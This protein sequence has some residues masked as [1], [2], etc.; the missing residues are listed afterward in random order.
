MNCARCLKNRQEVY[1]CDRCRRGFCEK[2]CGEVISPTE[3]RVMQLKK[4]RKLMY[5]CGDCRSKYCQ[6]RDYKEVVKEAFREEMNLMRGIY[7]EELRKWQEQ[8]MKMVE[9]KM[10]SLSNTAMKASPQSY[11]MVAKK[12]MMEPALVV[13]PILEQNSKDTK[14]DIREKINP[15]ELGVGVS[16]FRE[17]AKGQ[18]IIKTDANGRA[19]LEEAIKTK[20]ADKYEVKLAKMRTP[21]VRLFGINK[22][23]DA[24]DDLMENNIIEQNNLDKTKQDFKLKISK[25]IYSKKYPKKMSLVLDVDPATYQ[26]LREKQKI[27][28]GWSMVRVEDYVS[29]VRCYKCLGYGHYAKECKNKQACFKCGS[30]HKGENCNVSEDK[31]DC[32]NCKRAVEKF[33]LNIGHNH[34]AY[35]KECACYLRILRNQQSKINYA[36]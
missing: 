6:E 3:M 21:N 4:E 35:S 29:V 14:S 23:D 12:Q 10:K 28:L 19:R 26:V 11:A 25:R 18:V 22:E 27:S 36:E 33:N 7:E 8:I 31:Y 17:A 34:S 30:E 15:T 24:E 9:D 32:I 16:Q 13:K 5:F 20:F 1:Y 2:C